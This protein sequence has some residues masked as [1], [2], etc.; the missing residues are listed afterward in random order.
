MHFLDGL[1][2]QLMQKRRDSFP[3]VGKCKRAAKTHG[4]MALL[5]EG[6]SMG[7]RFMQMKCSKYSSGLIDC[8]WFQGSIQYTVAMIDSQLK[9]FGD[10]FFVQVGKNAKLPIRPKASNYNLF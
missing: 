9:R 6:K 10:V 4:I 1:T 7:C 3:G 5:M 2:M 8:E